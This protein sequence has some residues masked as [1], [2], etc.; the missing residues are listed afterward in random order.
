MPGEIQIKQFE[1]SERESLLAFLREAYPSEP[2]KSDPAYWDWHYLENPYA[3]PENIPVWIVKDGERIVGQAG[4]I[5]VELKVGGEI[6]RAVWMLEFVLL[7]EYRGKKLG[8]KLLLLAGETYPTQLA[9][10]YNELAGNVIRSLDWV[11]MGTIHRYQR[12]LYPGHS[13]AEIA[14]SLPLRELVNFSYAPLRP[15][16]S[17]T[18]ASGRFAVKEIENF[19]ESFDHLWTRASEQWPCAVIRSA[20]LLEWQFKKQ[21]GKKFEVLGVHDGARLLGYVVLF[22][23]KAGASGASPK[24]AISDITYDPHE[25]NAII[26]ELLKAS[27][28][29]A[30]ERRAG[31]LV[32]D[33]LDARTEERLHRFG[34][35]R[36]K[37]A[38]PF[39]VY[40]PKQQELMYKPNNWFLTRADSD[41]SIFEDPNL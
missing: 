36:I 38:P 18:L 15:R 16:R 23:R 29:L 4:A 35:W 10:G 1:L 27:L 12:L 25:P 13:L 22:F 33:V 8:K 14:G 28:R 17:R 11:T 24:V 32:T 21:P 5:P 26:D 3:S 40:S 6:R 39:M 9:L 37:A 30:V 34:F 2:R 7:P 31:S 41:V 20:K 19:N